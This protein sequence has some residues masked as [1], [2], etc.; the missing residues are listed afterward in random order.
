ML[1]V[2]QLTCFLAAYEHGSLTRA[3]E[4]LGYAQP[5]VSEQIRALEKTLGVELFR[6]V[7]RGVVPPTVGDTL[8]RQRHL[9]REPCH[10]HRAGE[11]ICP[12]REFV[13]TLAAQ[14]PIDR[15]ESR[16]GQRRERDCG[17]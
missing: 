5:S 10:P 13:F 16:V 4:H 11:F 3:A 15:P 7:G 8:R 2:H 14:Q 6:R 1:S 9:L 17:R 12:Y